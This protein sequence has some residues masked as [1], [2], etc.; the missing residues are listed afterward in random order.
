[1]RKNVIDASTWDA[2]V[3][4]RCH[5]G[6]L[7]PPSNETTMNCGGSPPVAA[8]DPVA[9]GDSIATPASNEEANAT[10]P[11]V[12]IFCRILRMTAR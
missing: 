3:R 9:V 11:P 12:R 1:M 5:A 10:R 6:M 4:Q 7:P 8:V 2:R